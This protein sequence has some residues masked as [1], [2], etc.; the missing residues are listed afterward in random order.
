MDKSKDPLFAVGF[1]TYYEM[2]KIVSKDVQP[3]YETPAAILPFAV[4]AIALRAIGGGKPASD[5]GSLVVERCVFQAVKT[6]LCGGRAATLIALVETVNASRGIYKLLFAGKERV[7]FR[8]N[9]DMQVVA[10]G[11][12]GLKAVPACARDRDLV[13]IRMYILFHNLF[14]SPKIGDAS[15][16]ANLKHTPKQ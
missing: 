13:V 3:K 10:Q 14:L 5:F 16:N 12:A 2:A 15:V 9:F 8:A 6:S 7:A 11:R 1:H 4:D